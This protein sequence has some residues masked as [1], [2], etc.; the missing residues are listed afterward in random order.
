AVFG[1]Y[2]H[3]WRDR[4][5]GLFAPFVRAFEDS[6]A[7]WRQASFWIAGV[8]AAYAA[9]LGLV[10]LIGFG[11]GHVAVDGVW[12]AA[13][14]AVLLAGLRLASADLVVGGFCWL[15]ATA[16][17]GGIHG[18]RQLA[19]SPRSV[20]YLLLAGA[21]LTAAATYERQRKV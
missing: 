2:S 3:R 9:A 4:Y 21:A 1:H 13:G 18:A 8:L 14:L 15:G 19:T 20:A 10:Q 16:V 11:W 17:I 7:E 12:A 5:D 6:Q